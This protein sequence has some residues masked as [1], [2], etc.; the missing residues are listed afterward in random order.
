[1]IAPAT[2]KTERHISES[3]PC[4]CVC[5]CEWE[6]LHRPNTA[7]LE[8]RVYYIISIPK[9]RRSAQ[10]GTSFVLLYRRHD[11]SN[12]CR[13][14]RLICPPRT[15]RVAHI[16]THMLTY[17]TLA[18]PLPIHAPP[19]LP[20]DALLPRFLLPFGRPRGRFAVPGCTSGGVS[21]VV[22]F[23]PFIRRSRKYWDVF[24]SN[25]VCRGGNGGCPSSTRRR[26]TS[27]FAVAYS[28]S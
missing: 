4:V 28:P 13:H 24:S 27:R 8:S 25:V 22:R 1:M 11:V 17:H 19:L 26:S 12:Q 20:P 21:L 23:S 14:T 2:T 16:H 7:P 10:L 15:G 18:Y 6:T 9:H 5:K 3:Q